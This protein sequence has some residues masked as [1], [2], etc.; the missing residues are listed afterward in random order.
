MT[1][2]GEIL[3]WSLMGDEALKSMF[4]FIPLQVILAIT[5]ISETVIPTN[6]KICPFFFIFLN[7]SCCCFLP[8]INIC[9]AGLRH[10]A[11][12]LY[13][14]PLHLHTCFFIFTDHRL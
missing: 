1:L 9:L 12:P 4:L 3:F 7:Q 2:Q 10:L 14:F 6:H 8:L 13:N 5:S 11:V